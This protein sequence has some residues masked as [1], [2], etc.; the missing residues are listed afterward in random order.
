MRHLCRVLLARGVAFG[1]AED[2]LCTAWGKAGE[3]LAERAPRE[4]PNT[5]RTTE[6]ALAEDRATACRAW[7]G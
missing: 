3:E 5:L 1:D 2:V 6:Q 4:V 7:R